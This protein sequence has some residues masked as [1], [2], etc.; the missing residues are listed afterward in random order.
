MDIY[1]NLITLIF[2]FYIIVTVISYVVLWEDWEEIEYVHGYEKA[3]KM[4]TYLPL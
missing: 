3:W 4:V 1:S 2:V